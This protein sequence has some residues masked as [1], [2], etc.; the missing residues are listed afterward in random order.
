VAEF[1]GATNIV[2]GLADN[3]S[4]VAGSG[5]R[6][7]LRTPD[8]GASTRPV[9]LGIRPENMHISAEKGTFDNNVPAKV[10]G[11]VFRGTTHAYQLRVAALSEEILVYRRTANRLDGQEFSIGQD[12]WLGWQVENSFLVV[13]Q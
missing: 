8:S 6:I 11:Y 13:K 3:G 2:S 12:V 7:V 1:L 9:T 5:D 4:M 10:A